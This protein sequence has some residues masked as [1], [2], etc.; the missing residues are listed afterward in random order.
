VLS[1]VGLINL[2]NQN[3]CQDTNPRPRRLKKKKNRFFFHHKNSTT[4]QVSK[5]NFSITTNSTAHLRH[6]H[7]HTLLTVYI[8]RPP[9]LFLLSFIDSEDPAASE[10]LNQESFSGQGRREGT[11]SAFPLRGILI[12]CLSPSR[13]LARTTA[14]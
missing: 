9:F 3:W 1:R 6:A 7:T 12:S 13:R 8:Y 4:T 2:K 5:L 10:R 14:F 11:C